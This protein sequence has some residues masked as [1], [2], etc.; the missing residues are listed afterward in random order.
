MEFETGGKFDVKLGYTLLP[1]DNSI[2][3]YGI[4]GLIRISFY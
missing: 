4:S 1:S 3:C 2:A